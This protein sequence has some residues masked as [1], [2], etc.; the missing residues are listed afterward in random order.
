[1]KF[2]KYFVAAGLILSTGFI[3]TPALANEAQIE[4][5]AKNIYHEARGQSQKG[6]IAVA[7][8]V[9]NRVESR[10]FP[11]SACSVINQ[12]TRKVC[13]FTWVCGSKK[14]IRE[15]NAWERAKELARKIYNRDIK[16]R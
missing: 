16:A 8:V 7:N 2:T 11:N 5:L 15:R 4:C 6:Q 10:K 12:R 13:Q 1:M 3:S 9:L 14:P